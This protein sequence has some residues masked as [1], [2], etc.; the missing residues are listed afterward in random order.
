MWLA[1]FPGGEE[2]S[3]ARSDGSIRWPI[4][5]LREE[6]NCRADLAAALPNTCA[7]L[8]PDYDVPRSPPIDIKTIQSHNFY[9]PH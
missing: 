3:P 1:F 5:A 4:G 2:A 6:G 7:P 9:K 8:L